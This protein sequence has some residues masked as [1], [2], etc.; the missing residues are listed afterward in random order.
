MTYLR[1]KLH[2]AT[3]HPQFLGTTI[4]WWRDTGETVQV[5]I[6]HEVAD[7]IP[8]EKNPVRRVCYGRET[9]RRRPD[10]PDDQLDFEELIVPRERRGTD[11][12]APP[13]GGVSSP[14]YNV[15]LGA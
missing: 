12:N 14:A 8:Y 1:K 4:T 2:T 10:L 13:V 7:A 15:Q 6:A 11:F 3:L 5:M 9:L